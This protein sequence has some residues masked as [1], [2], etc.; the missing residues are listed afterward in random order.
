MRR[1]HKLYTFHI[2]K[3]REEK[4]GVRGRLPGE[5][6][7]QCDKQSLS[8]VC[9]IKE[10]QTDE[11][12]PALLFHLCWEESEGSVSSVSTTLWI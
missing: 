12:S 2:Y 5:S 11:N 10:S 3:R 1:I 7:D 8:K 4:N 6:L 9:P